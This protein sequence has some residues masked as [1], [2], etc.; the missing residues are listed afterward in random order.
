MSIAASFSQAVRKINDASARAV[1]H[2]LPERHI[3][4]QHLFPFTSQLT[5]GPD[6]KLGPGQQK[7][8]G[9]GK[10]KSIPTHQIQPKVFAFGT[11]PTNFQTTGTA[12]QSTADTN[13]TIA[14]VSATGLRPYDLLRNKRTG[15]Q[16]QVRSVSGLTVTFRG[17]AG[18][19]VGGGLDAI[20]AGDAYDFVGN[21]YPDGA[22]LQNGNTTEPVERSNYLQ[23]H[24]TETDMGWFA[25]KRKLYPD[26]MNGGDTDEMVNAM[27]HQEGRERAFLFGQGGLVTIASELIMAMSGLT[28]LSTL[29]YDAGGTITMDEFRNT[30]APFVF[31]GGG[32]GMRKGVAG[33]TV[34]GVFDSLMDGKVVFTE[35]KDEYAIR[36]RKLGAPAGNV[37]VM[38]SQPMNEREGEI[39]F[40]NPD[41]LTHLYLEGFDTVLFEGMAPENVLKTSNALI[42]V[43][44]ILEPNLD[45]ITHVTNVLA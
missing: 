31:Q 19:L 25:A 16:I 36:C 42:S 24:V 12:V 2:V 37:E 10:I 9:P 35:P 27:R 30:I 13:A 3:F 11:M 40:Y 8:R 20:N 33:N 23:A 29:E 43:E 41:T 39:V 44:T 1:P 17:F 38:G 26:Q 22:T 7:F 18:G 45:N 32:G 15:A 4:S 34:L 28:V 5:G 6:P 21:S 14:M